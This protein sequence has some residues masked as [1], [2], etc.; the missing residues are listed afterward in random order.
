MPQPQ[1]LINEDV[2]AWKQAKARRER[3]RHYQSMCKKVD[4]LEQIVEQLQKQ[5]KE[6]T[7]K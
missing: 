1:V 4:T 7:E 2:N 3:E 6:I 5:I